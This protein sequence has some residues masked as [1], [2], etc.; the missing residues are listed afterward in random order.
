MPKYSAAIAQW[1]LP[2]PDSAEALSLIEPQSYVETSNGPIDVPWPPL[3]FIE[4]ANAAALAEDWQIPTGFV[5]VMGDFHGL[6]CLAFENESTPQVVLINDD[7][8]ELARFPSIEKFIAAIQRKA[9]APIDTSSVV[10]D[11]S[12]LNF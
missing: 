7:R 1:N 12:W 4:I 11:K 10:K 9:E 5:P 3:S 8:V 2:I 6:V